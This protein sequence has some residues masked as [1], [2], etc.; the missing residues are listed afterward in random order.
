MRFSTQI[1][2]LL[3]SQRPAKFL[4][5]GKKASSYEYN[6][7]VALDKYQFSYLFQVDHWGGRRLRGG[8]VL[9]FLVFTTPMP[10]PLWVNGDY[11]HKGGTQS[12]IDYLQQVLLDIENRGRW[13]PAIVLWGK[14]TETIEAADASIRKVFGVA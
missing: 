12:T 10:T 2:G 6:V 11:F 8:I 5:R 9:D 13:R 3:P 7:A 14:D 4:V 1:P